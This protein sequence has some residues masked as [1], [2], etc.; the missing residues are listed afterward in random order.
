M[1]HWETDMVLYEA[2]WCLTPLTIFQP[3][4][5]SKAEFATLSMFSLLHT[6]V[7]AEIWSKSTFS[8]VFVVM[9][10]LSVPNEQ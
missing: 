7:L 4:V 5:S 10:L 1:K 8:F 9:C 6:V 2:D 3:H